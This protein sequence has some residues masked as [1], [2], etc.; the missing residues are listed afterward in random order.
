MLVSEYITSYKFPL[1]YKEAD[2]GMFGQILGR[3]FN[4]SLLFRTHSKALLGESE[5][6]E[7]IIHCLIFWVRE[8]SGLRDFEK[9]KYKVQNSNARALNYIGEAKDSFLV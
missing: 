4:D 5:K 2:S 8:R 3:N 7:F 9:K 6:T 1:R